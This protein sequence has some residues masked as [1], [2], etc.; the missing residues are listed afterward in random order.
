MTS[1]SSSHKQGTYPYA[2]L[3]TIDNQLSKEMQDTRIMPEP[4]FI[5]LADTIQE[6]PDFDCYRAPEWNRRRIRGKDLEDVM[7]LDPTVAEAYRQ[8]THKMPED[9]GSFKCQMVWKRFADSDAP[10]SF[11]NAKNFGAWR[12]RYSLPE[13]CIFDI[14]ARQNPKDRTVCGGLGVNSPHDASRD[15]TAG[16]KAKRKAGSTGGKAGAEC[17]RTDAE[18][19][20]D[21]ETANAAAA[22]EHQEE[23]EDEVDDSDIPALV[24]AED[25][26][27]TVKVGFQ[28]DSNL[29]HIRLYFR[30]R[31]SFGKTRNVVAYVF[32]ST[33]SSSPVTDG[34]ID[35]GFKLRYPFVMPRG[36]MAQ[37]EAYDYHIQQQ[38]AELPP[39]QSLTH[40]QRDQLHWSNQK[41]TLVDTVVQLYLP[42]KNVKWTGISESELSDLSSKVLMG[43]GMDS[44]SKAIGMLQ[45]HN[46]R[47]RI[48]R[49]WTREKNDEMRARLQRFFYF[50]NCCYLAI[51]YGNMWYFRHEL[52]RIAEAR[53]G[54]LD[55][56]AFHKMQ[57]HEHFDWPDILPPPWLVTQWDLCSRQVDGETHLVPV[58]WVSF[59]LPPVLPDSDTAF[60]VNLLAYH[61]VRRDIKKR[62]F[63]LRD[64]LKGM[65]ATAVFTL[66]VGGSGTVIAKVKWEEN[67]FAQ[68]ISDSNTAQKSGTINSTVRPEG[69]T[70]V[71]VK[72]II[73][74]KGQV[75]L[76][77]LFG[78]VFDL[79]VA[80]A[81]TVFALRTSRPSALVAGRSYRVEVDWVDEPVSVNRVINSMYALYNKPRKENTGG[82]DLIWLYFGGE[83]KTWEQKGLSHELSTNSSQ[84][85]LYE[86]ALDCSCNDAQRKAIDRPLNQ[87]FDQTFIWGGP[88]TG[89]TWMAQQ[90]VKG[91]VRSGQRVLVV[92]ATHA[93]LDAAIAKVNKDRIIAVRFMGMSNSPKSSE[94]AAETSSDGGL[95][96]QM[97]RQLVRQD[98]DVDADLL[99]W[100]QFEAWVHRTAK[101][102]KTVDDAT[103]NECIDE[104]LQYENTMEELKAVAITANAKLQAQRLV[105]ELEARLQTYFIS[106]IV[107]VVYVTCSASATKILCENFKPTVL[108]VEE[109]GQVTVGELAPTIYH[110][111]DSVKYVFESG[112]HMQNGPTTFTTD[113]NEMQR[114]INT[115]QFEQIMKDSCFNDRVIQLA[116]QYRAHPDLGDMTSRL[117]YKGNIAHDESVKEPQPIDAIVQAW[118]AATFGGAFPSNRNVGIDC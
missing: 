56:A 89:K 55:P 33:M 83:R 2:N 1:S 99:Y 19:D 65:T 112:D 63:K 82:V 45:G 90:A 98:W 117:F 74:D 58:T 103:G 93:A 34:S 107:D 75:I 87:R 108:V 57:L 86:E 32:A 102:N 38:A 27:D 4:D 26:Q 91:F 95:D 106:Q 67:K 116:V 13:G 40:K 36:K 88:G 114:A 6:D 42:Y 59:D 49:H 22:E 8:I 5:P 70:R 37:T 31:D 50:R 72:V 16:T 21:M 48:Y 44:V 29:P 24:W 3:L 46:N 69:G 78:Q 84:M 110:Y 43:E 53:G 104:C 113:T 30:W 60:F 23:A 14:E 39:E 101:S 79:S 73:K 54:Q 52:I 77:P 51:R 66:D 76:I 68:M 12:F 100:N 11:E 105:L 28:H 111:G 96:W 115:S 109:G 61:R 17:P 25:A 9:E 15:W 97:I 80:N 118:G 18:V 10:V 47:F 41:G 35:I 64:A 71:K 20:V 7:K 85:Q 62:L 81:D 94:S 92:A